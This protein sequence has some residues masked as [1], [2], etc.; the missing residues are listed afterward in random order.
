MKLGL[1]AIRDNNGI[2]SS[3][4]FGDDEEKVSKFYLKQF[5]NVLKS[6]DTDKEVD[7]NNFNFFLLQTKKCKLV[8]IGFLD[9]ETAELQND[10]AVL[11]DLKDYE[12][13]R[14]EKV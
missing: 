7:V 6:L 10:F 8:R 3:F 9:V 2:V 11:V 12:F 5:D 14:K 13:K 1:Y 4:M